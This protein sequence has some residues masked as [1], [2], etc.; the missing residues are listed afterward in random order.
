MRPLASALE[1]E[2]AMLRGFDS[3]RPLSLSPVSTLRQVGAV[4]KEYKIARPT[5]LKLMECS[6]PVFSAR[7]RGSY[8]TRKRAESPALRP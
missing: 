2:V 4:V 1:L 5:V 6:C 3:A 8:D 7:P